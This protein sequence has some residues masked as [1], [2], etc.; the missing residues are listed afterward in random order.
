MHLDVYGVLFAP[1]VWRIGQ[2]TGRPDLQRLALVMFRSCGQLID[3]AGSQGEQIEQ[4]NYTQQ[5]T[6]FGPGGLR[7]GYSEH[8]TVFWITAH[9]LTAAAQF[10]EL[11]VEMD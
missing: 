2:L 7:G 3:A 4:T 8:W 5:R 6:G 9:F 1:D 10:A 11:G